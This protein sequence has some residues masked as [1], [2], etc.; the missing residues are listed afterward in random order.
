MKR[1]LP[2]VLIVLISVVLSLAL[3]EAGLWLLGIEYPDFYAYDPVLGSKLRPGIKGYFLEEGGGYVSINSDGL[4]DREHSLDKPP[5][6]LRIAVLGDSFTEA[7]Q[8]D[9]EEAFW[10]VMERDLQSCA[11]LGDSRVEVIN[12]GQSGF[13]TS[14]E[15]LALRHQAWKYSP[16]VVLLAFFSGNDVADNSRSLKQKDY[17]PYHVFRDGRLVLDDSGTM[18]KW[19]ELQR[20]SWAEK[21]KRWRQDNFRVF[22]VLNQGLDTAQTWW[23]QFMTGG[24]TAVAGQSPEPGLLD[25]V[26][27][28]PTDP[29]W[30]EAWKVTEAVLLEMRDEVAAQGANFFVVVLTNGIQVHPD[31]EERK[32]SAQKIGV[33]DLL[34][35]DRRLKKFCRGHDIPILLLAPAFQ[36]YATEYQV[37]FHGFGDSLGGGHWNRT[38]HRLAGEMLAEWLCR[39]IN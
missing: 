15:L 37:F 34:Y 19:A 7:M 3:C 11:P 23:T 33:Q 14:Q 8:V 9:R 13:G 38:G 12:F 27:R 29:V 28:P 20:R 25:A 18:E 5:S 32:K 17:D 26:Y 21:F 16:D 1:W 2:K 4:R 39:Q 24:Q 36:A 30:Q 6:T 22:Q 31:P 35:P 10:A